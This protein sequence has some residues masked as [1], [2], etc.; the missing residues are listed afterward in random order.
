MS[1]LE[2]CLVCGSQLQYGKISRQPAC[3]LRSPTSS[4][5]PHTEQL[6]R[7]P[8]LN[9]SPQ[10]AACGLLPLTI[11]PTLQASCMMVEIP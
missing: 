11:P 1:C 9:T 6:C 10:C 5:D 8:M 7:I 4:C 3:L 2:S